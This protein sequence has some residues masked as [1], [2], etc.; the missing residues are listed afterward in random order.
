VSDHPTAARSADPA[1]VPA[2]ATPGLDG[3]ALRAARKE[4]AAVERR[5]SK[6]QGQIAI[7]DTKMAEHDPADYGGLTALGEE[8]HAR[9]AEL[10]AEE[11]R[12]M[13]L[14]EAVEG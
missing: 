2:D 4:L 5:V 12:W 6:I 9:Q 11:E 1:D 13:E 8:K 10:A 3:A 14:A 7:L